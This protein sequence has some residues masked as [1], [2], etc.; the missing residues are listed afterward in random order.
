MA[1]TIAKVVDWDWQ[2]QISRDDLLSTLST[3]GK[4]LLADKLITACTMFYIC[5]LPWSRSYFG[6]GQHY[7]KNKPF[8]KKFMAGY[9]YFMSVYSLVTFIVCSYA[10]SRNKLYIPDCERLWK[11][12]VFYWVAL[13]FYW[14]KFV[15][16]LDSFF[17][18]VRGVPVSYLHW[19][20]HIGAAFSLKFGLLYLAEP[21]W[22]FVWL[23]SF[24][25]TIMYWY[26]AS[27]VFP[28]SGN[29]LFSI[30]KPY[31]TV[32]QII[33]FNVGFYY[34]WPYPRQV[35]CFK[36]DPFQM[37]GV[38]Y[39]TWFYVGVVLFLFLN[40]FIHSYMCS[41]KKHSKKP[42]PAS[43]RTP[44]KAPDFDPKEAKAEIGKRPRMERRGKRSKNE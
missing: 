43:P 33:Q 11:D 31:I 3:M 29:R 22:I 40:F 1:S 8:W 21:L 4:T 28:T 37:I 34:I 41:S 2:L 17:L 24:V 16:Y 42:V 44:V 19:F 38:Y 27:S 39:F 32:I 7:E 13:V 36:N 14:S 12:P 25:H 18:Y 5:V 20:H 10:L 26:Y 15:E 35:P 23:N 30:L 9:N 6:N